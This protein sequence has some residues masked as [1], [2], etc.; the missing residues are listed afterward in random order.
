MKRFF[1]RVRCKILE[2]AE[3]AVTRKY[4]FSAWI[5]FQQRRFIRRWGRYIR[6]RRK[7]IRTSR[8]SPGSRTTAASIAAAMAGSTAG[9]QEEGEEAYVDRV[10]SLSSDYYYQHHQQQHMSTG[11]GGGTGGFSVSSAGVTGVTGAS[12]GF[13]GGGLFLQRPGEYDA[14]KMDRTDGTDRKRPNDLGSAIHE[15]GAT[16]GTGGTGGGGDYFDTMSGPT[17]YPNT[18]R[19]FFYQGDGLGGEGYDTRGTSGG[20]GGSCSVNTGITGSKRNPR[21]RSAHQLQQQKGAN[22]FQQ[23]VTVHVISHMKKRWVRTFLQVFVYYSA[24]QRRQRLCI[25]AAVQQYIVRIASQYLAR[26]HRHVRKDVKRRRQYRHFMCSLIFHGW[27]SYVNEQK[28]EARLQRGLIELEQ[29]AVAKSKAVAL[30]QWREVVQKNKRLDRTK[31]FLHTKKHHHRLRNSFTKWRSC[32]SSTL[33]W[34]LKELEAD[35]NRATALNEL[36]KQV[37]DDFET[38]KKKNLEVTAELQRSVVQLQ[39]TVADSKVECEQQR[40]QVAAKEEEKE[41][42]LRELLE[43]QRELQTVLVERENM[44]EFESLLVKELQQQEA[45]KVRVQQAADDVMRRV[46]Q[47]SNSLRYEVEAAREQAMRAESQADSLVRRSQEEAQQAQ[48]QAA[49]L[50]SVAQRR[51]GEVGELE[52][53]QLELQDHLYRVQ[54]KLDQVS[55]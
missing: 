13:G 23:D 38:E 42:A 39:V 44:K 37:L 53:E 25:R 33:Y 34:R 47:E 14:A 16:G 49:D 48:R 32:W 8:M 29:R 36:N 4:A 22:R 31:E 11:G 2:R 19:G 5:A 20:G 24:V 27:V 41:A 10:R 3:S 15:A 7:F 52:R 40:R 45:E 1:R 6:S 26:W 46:N 12:A 18:P 43:L 21:Y 51:A 54:Q 55:R 28:A 9:E 50:Q 30:A 17:S 35:Y